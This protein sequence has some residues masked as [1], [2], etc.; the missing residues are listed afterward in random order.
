MQDVMTIATPHVIQVPRTIQTRMMAT[1][2]PGDK[3]VGTPGWSVVLKPGCIVG[4]VG[5]V[6]TI[7]GTAEEKAVRE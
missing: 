5:T 1:M 2:T 3:L 6:V 4:A 7:G